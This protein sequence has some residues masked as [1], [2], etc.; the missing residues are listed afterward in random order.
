MAPVAVANAADLGLPP[1]PP[2]PE[3]RIGCTGPVYFKGFIGAANPMV[4]DVST[5]LFE[6]NDFEVFHEDIAASRSSS[7]RI[8]IVAATALSAG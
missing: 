8:A 2:L 6:F 1:P 3:P 7:P 5:K 4:G